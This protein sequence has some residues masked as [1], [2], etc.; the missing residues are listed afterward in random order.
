MKFIVSLILLSL[1]V[2]CGSDGDSSKTVSPGIQP[3]NGQTEI[4]IQE[5]ETLINDYVSKKKYEV[6]VGESIEINE[7]GDTFVE[8]N[9]GSSVRCKEETVTTK[10][11]V[12]INYNE[13][14]IYVDENSKISCP[15]EVSE[16]RERLIEVHKKSDFYGV[17]LL[18]SQTDLSKV[19]NLKIFL[20]SYEGERAILIKGE[21]DFFDIPA[22]I[23]GVSS[24]EGSALSSL[25]EFYS[26][27]RFDGQTMH[28]QG[29]RKKIHDIEPSRLELDG[30]PRYHVTQ[31]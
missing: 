17:E 27:F 24:L 28:Q 21:I 5:L 13:I 15:S 23:S 19:S 6:Y 1:V 3:L 18:G 31:E 9:E 10:T 14:E 30:L 25:K 8:D 4:S 7:S 2:S 22:K 29:K 16:E 26:E 20:G 12:N 11:V